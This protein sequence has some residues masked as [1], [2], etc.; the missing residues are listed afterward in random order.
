MLTKEQIETAIRQQIEKDEKLG[1]QSGGSGHMGYVDYVIDMIGKPCE[2][3]GVAFEQVESVAE[4]DDDANAGQIS[5]NHRIGNK[6][7]EP[8]AANRTVEN[9]QAG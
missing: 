1:E 2:K 6:F 5:A 9:L 8:P 4:H 7:D 3:D